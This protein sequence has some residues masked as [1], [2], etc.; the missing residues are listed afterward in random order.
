MSTRK[1]KIV[2]AMR[3]DDDSTL[4][5]QF[6]RPLTYVEFKGIVQA[7]EDAVKS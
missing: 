7:V 6:S 4:A 3:K 1:L 5:I 2:G